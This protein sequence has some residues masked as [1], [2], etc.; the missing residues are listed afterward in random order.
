MNAA[1]PN[2]VCVRVYDVASNARAIPK[3]INRGPSGARITFAGF[4]SR[5]TNSCACTAISPSANP[6]PS[7][8]TEPAGNTRYSAT[9]CCNDIPGMNAVANHGRESSVSASSTSAV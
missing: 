4:R 1:V 6:A 3:S 8:A 5:C 7:I 2:T 9:A